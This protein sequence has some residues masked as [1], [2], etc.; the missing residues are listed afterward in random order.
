MILSELSWSAEVG[1]RYFY[2]S[3]LPLVR[4]LES[5][6]ASRWSATYKN[7]VVH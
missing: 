7:L 6:S 5:A 3:P 4:Y 2:R 1:T